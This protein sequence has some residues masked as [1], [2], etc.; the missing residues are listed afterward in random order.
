MLK[1]P[2]KDPDATIDYGFDWSAWLSDDD[3]ISSSTWLLIMDDPTDDDLQL[4]LESFDSLK[5]KVWF[6]KGVT[7]MRYKVTNRI[8]TSQGRKT[9]KTATIYIAEQ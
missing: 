6:D 1:F 7:N 8:T 9:D 2:D 5:T 3:T 4:N